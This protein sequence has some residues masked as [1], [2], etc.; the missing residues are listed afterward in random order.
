MAGKDGKLW[1]WAPFAVVLLDIIAGEI[2]DDL[3]AA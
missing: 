2:V 3:E 1:Y